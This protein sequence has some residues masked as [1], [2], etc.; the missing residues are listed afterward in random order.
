MIVKEEKTNQANIIIRIVSVVII[1]FSLWTIS[2]QK[3]YCR[4]T[5]DELTAYAQKN[6]SIVQRVLGYRYEMG[7]GVATAP[8]TAFMLYQKAAQQGNTT[9]MYNLAKLYTKGRGVQ[10]NLDK[11]IHWYKKI[12]EVEPDNLNTLYSLGWAYMKKEDYTQAMR[13]YRVASDKGSIEAQSAIAWLYRQGLGV[14]QDKVKSVELY[15]R[16]AEK[17]DSN[18]MINLAKAYLNG[19][20]IDKNVEKAMGLYHK[21]ADAGNATAQGY[22]GYLYV[23]GEVQGYVFGRNYEKALIYIKQGAA[24]QDSLSQYLM[25]WMYH[26]GEGLRRDFVKA[27]EWYKKAAAQNMPNAINNIGQMYE[28]GEGVIADKNEAIKWYRRAAELNNKEAK[29]NLARLRRQ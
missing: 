23:M 15:L 5:I 13:W 24:Q 3:N 18:A 12:I 2:T 10:E 17:G 9:A 20:G 1:V 26:Q 8:Q 7:I 22:L 19:E 11:A 6:D 29:A 21:A 4:M 14:P 25:G 27:M 28:Q 16:A